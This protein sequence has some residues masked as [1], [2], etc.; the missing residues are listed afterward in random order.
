MFE[1]IYESPE[2]RKNK[3]NIIREIKLNKKYGAGI[4]SAN[5]DKTIYLHIINV[6]R[7]I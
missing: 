2:M 6:R 1:F 7:V 3:I 4:F 5:I